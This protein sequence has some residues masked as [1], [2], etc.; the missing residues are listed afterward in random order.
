M[1]WCGVRERTPPPIPPPPHP[2]PLEMYIPWGSE[3][4]VLMRIL[5]MVGVDNLSAFTAHSYNMTIYDPAD[6][7][8]GIR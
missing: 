5:S 4:G 1:V 2:L 7:K 8:R 3:S 6:K